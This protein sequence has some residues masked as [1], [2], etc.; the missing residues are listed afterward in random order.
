MEAPWQ[1]GPKLRFHSCCPE[2]LVS[3]WRDFELPP[4]FLSVLL[5][6]QEW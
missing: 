5:R 2:L 6:P 3:S 1:Q 4:S